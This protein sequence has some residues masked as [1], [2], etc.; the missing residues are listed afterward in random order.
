MIPLIF[1]WLAMVS[2][3]GV[4]YLVAKRMYLLRR[5]SETF[6]ADEPSIHMFVKPT[7]DYSAFRLVTG[8]KQASHWLAISGL[9][10]TGKLLT[11]FKFI[12]IK[13]EHRFSKVVN[14]VRGKGSIGKRGSVSIFLKEIEEHKNSLRFTEK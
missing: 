14:S 6:H 10:L 1:S 7:I 13:L 9:E 2:G 3:L 5:T 12:V 8:L 11:V 4:V